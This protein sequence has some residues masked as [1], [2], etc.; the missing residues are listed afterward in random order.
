MS[1]GPLSEF[2]TLAEAA[3]LAPGRPSASAIWRWARRGI[4]SRTGVRIKLHHV[5]AGRRVFTTVADLRRFLAAVAEA[6]SPYFDEKPGGASPSRRRS[7]RDGRRAV[8][9]AEE[10]LE[11]EGI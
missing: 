5:R 3:K 11:S 7:D 1:V 2:I 8:A 9:R 6:D 10:A 4:K